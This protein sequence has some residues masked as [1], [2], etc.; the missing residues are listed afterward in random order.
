MNWELQNEKM[1]YLSPERLEKMIQTS[2]GNSCVMEIV[3]KRNCR[4]N[5]T[6]CI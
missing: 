1:L 3:K 5:D 6:L 2:F 4:P